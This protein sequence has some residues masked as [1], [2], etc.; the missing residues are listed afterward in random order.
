M[1][2]WVLTL[3]MLMICACSSERTESTANITDAIPVNSD[4]IIQFNELKKTNNKIKSFGWWKELSKI[5]SIKS[6]IEKIEAVYKTYDLQEV[7]QNKNKPVFLSL[8]IIGKNK[9]DFLFTTSISDAIIKSN[10]LLRTIHSNQNKSKVYDGVQINNIEFS[11]NNIKTNVFFSIHNNIFLL[12]FSE[13][14]IQESIRQLDNGINIFEL[15]PIKNLH[16]KLPR[17]SNITAIVK[18]KF[19][20]EMIEQ[21]NIF[22][23]FG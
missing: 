2:N 13:I 6:E 15:E 11:T 20:E 22:L 8:N 21:K 19:L 1:K 9:P 17:Y 3:L 14:I 16:S 12:S 23:N 7:F 4:L 10:K 5:K 18:T